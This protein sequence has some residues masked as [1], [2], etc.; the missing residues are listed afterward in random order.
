MSETSLNT[1]VEEIG[2][3][4]KRVRSLLKMNPQRLTTIQ[5]HLNL[6][7]QQTLTVMERLE[8][9]GE[10]CCRLG[11]WRLTDDE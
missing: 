10:V 1:R 7:K 8:Q 6:T 9:K 3:H 5:T 11:V 4:M 2:E